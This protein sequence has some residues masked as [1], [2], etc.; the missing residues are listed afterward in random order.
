MENLK[1]FLYLAL[2]AQIDTIL[3][4]E[5]N[6]V[7]RY[8]NHNLGFLDEDIPQLLYP[9]VLIDFRA[10]QYS[11]M[12]R[13]VQIGEGQVVLTVVFAPYSG[14]SNVTNE[15]FRKKGLGFYEKENALHKAIQGWSPAYMVETTDV[16]EFCGAFDR[17]SDDTD[18]KRKDVRIRR[19]TYSIGF[20]DYGTMAQLTLIPA[21]PPGIDP[22]F[23]LPPAIDAELIDL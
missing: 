16:L 22:D 10:F 19:I 18:M 5:G 21:P 11:N 12:S 13:N 17:V 15:E 3:D 20:E 6:K 2:Q 8:V 9:A 23:T 14:T 4:S 1:S 7:F